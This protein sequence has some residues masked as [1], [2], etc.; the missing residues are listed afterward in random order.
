MSAV[1]SREVM[2]RDRICRSAQMDGSGS[3]LVVIAELRFECNSLF[4]LA[5]V[6]NQTRPRALGSYNSVPVPSI[7]T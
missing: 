1:I 7:R 2:R 3:L 5:F 6:V 4:V